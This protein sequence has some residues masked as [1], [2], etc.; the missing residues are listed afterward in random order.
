MSITN[1]SYTRIDS[2][3]H[4]LTPIVTGTSVLGVKYKGGVMIAADCLGSYGSLARFR[5]ISRIYKVNDHCIV[6]GSGDYAD[7]QYIMDMLKELQMEHEIVHD[8]Y[9]LTPKAVHSFLE[10]VL[11]NR[12]SKMNPL[13]NQLVIAGVD[14]DGNQTLGFVDKLGVSFETDTMGTGYGAYI[15]LP[16]MRNAHEANPDMSE[17]QAKTLLED[18][19]RVMFYRDAR[20]LN[21][22]EIAKIDS[23]GVSVS[24]PFAV[25]TNWD[26]ANYVK[27]YC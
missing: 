2:K 3:Q 22:I 4:T 16:L 9:K 8:G 25:D 15:A 27:G 26:I 14:D 13:W 12:R 18:C 10:R 1:G 23:S 19:L 17:S 20:S 21:K 7:F 11:Y 5:D 24:A 6:A